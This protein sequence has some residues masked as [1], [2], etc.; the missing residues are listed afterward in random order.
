MDTIADV[1]KACTPQIIRALEKGHVDSAWKKYHLQTIPF[2]SSFNRA[3]AEGEKGS[4][5]CI[6]LGDCSILCLSGR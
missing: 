4:E 1:A 2:G 5:F 6:F 3:E